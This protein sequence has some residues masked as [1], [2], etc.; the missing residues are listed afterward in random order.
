MF[1]G[2]VLPSLLRLPTRLLSISAAAPADT[3]LPGDLLVRD[4]TL[5]VPVDHAA[6]TGGRFGSLDVFVRE[7][8]PASKAADTD[9][10][11]LLYLQGGPGFPSRRPTSPPSGWTKAALA[12][13]YRILLLDQRGTGR[14]T[15]VT[16]QSLGALSSPAEQAEYLSHFRADSIVRDCEVVRKKLCNGAKLTLLGQSFGGFCILTYL[17]LFPESIERGIFT[18]GLAPVG[19]SAEEVY[20]ATFGR[21]EERCRRFYERCESCHTNWTTPSLS[22]SPPPRALL[23]FL[24]AASCSTAVPSPARLPR[25]QTRR[26]W[27]SYEASSPTCMSSRWRCREVAR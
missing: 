17:S 26:T 24:P 3:I 11:C 7:I 18:F 10:P 23:S 27:S 5:R 20:T 4:H 12:R 13:N 1:F 21:M 8:V 16:T 25:S 9:L 19:R 14:S 22:S 2:R 15:P 6:G